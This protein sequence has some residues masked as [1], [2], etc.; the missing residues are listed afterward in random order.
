MPALEIIDLRVAFGPVEVLRG[1]SL[2]VEPRETLGIVGESGC[3]K[4][5]T[6]LAVMGLLP[7]GGRVS[8]GRIFLGDT[9]L[10]A[11]PERKLRELRGSD[12]AM[13]FQDP[14]TSLNPMMRVGRQI[15]EALSLH[16][17][18][19]RRKARRRA[20]EQLEAV[21]VPAPKSMARKF[22]HQ[23]SGGQR[24]R[25]MVAMAFA[26]HP[27][28]LIADEPTTALDVT[29]QAQ[30][31]VLLKELQEQQGTAVLLI[32][33]DI[34]VIGSV[35]DRIAVYY[36]GRVVEH[37][38]AEA[39]LKTPVHP[40]TQGLLGALPGDTER[41]VSIPGRPPDF[42]TLGAECSFAPRCAH[43]FE[44]CSIEP[45]L[46]APAK[47]KTAEQRALEHD[48][49][50]VDLDNTEIPGNVIALLPEKAAR[51]HELVPV[52]LLQNV[53]VVAMSEP[54]DKKAANAARTAAGC[55]ILPVM[56]D[57]AAILRAITKHYGGE[58][59]VQAEEPQDTEHTGACWLVQ[60]PGAGARETMDD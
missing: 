30:I 48:F 49:R 52:K 58:P 21:K 13:V 10:L 38:S 55:R 34:G 12:I 2:S 51:K 7:P 11:L 47:P 29:L 27:K 31:L 9:D 23:L 60:E 20:V 56:A 46:L 4:S 43:R 17:G 57:R 14:F 3:G 22:P 5:M 6:G 39:V 35:S 36:A 32:S 19:S 24:Q 42:A 33:H 8:G 54:A 44:K 25:V 16:Q 15:A 53:L 59:P 50:F 18:L 26:C 28:V 37:G 41:L 1:V 40:Y 45:S